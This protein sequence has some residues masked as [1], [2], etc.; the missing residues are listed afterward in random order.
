MSDN[1]GFPGLDEV[2]PVEP[3]R[4]VRC[5]GRWQVDDDEE[6]RAP[7]VYVCGC[8][9]CLREDED[10]RFHCCTDPAHVREAA[11]KHDRVRG[12]PALWYKT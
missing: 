7:V 1:E 11:R 10:E 6:C 3:L 2:T 8:H 9:R 5:D 12:R 4:A